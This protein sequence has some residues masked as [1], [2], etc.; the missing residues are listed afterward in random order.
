MPLDASPPVRVSESAPYVALVRFQVDVTTPGLVRFHPNSLGIL[1]F[2]VDQAKTDPAETIELSLT[3]G[4]HSLTFAG[5]LNQRF[6][7]LRCELVDVSGSLARAR[8][9]VYK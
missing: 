4:L 9:A 5:D 2:Q 7:G 6:D 8:I 3:A 1:E